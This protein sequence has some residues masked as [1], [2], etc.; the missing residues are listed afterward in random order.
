MNT[1]GSASSPLTKLCLTGSEVI[2]GAAS[3]P[4][5]EH[6][7]AKHAVNSALLHATQQEAEQ[8]NRTVNW[9]SQK[10]TLLSSVHWPSRIAPCLPLGGRLGN[11]CT[12]GVPHTRLGCCLAPARFPERPEQRWNCRK[13]PSRV[14]LMP[15]APGDCGAQ[16]C[17][18]HFCLI[19][20]L[21]EI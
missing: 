13:R 4:Q 18:L 19:I 21:K 12:M 1:T 5:S 7:P 10:A 2:F 20:S 17:S 6:L 15:P 11:L 8:T 14:D 9:T 3:E 16:K